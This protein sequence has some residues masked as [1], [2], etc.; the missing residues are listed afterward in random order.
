MMTYGWAILVVMAVGIV[1]WQTGVLNPSGATNG[2]RGFSQLD[3]LDWRM[4][5]SNGDWNLTLVVQNNAKTIVELGDT[6]D[7]AGA[8]AL[9]GGSGICGGIVEPSGPFPI[10]DFRPGQIMKIV[11]ELC[12]MDAELTYGDF[13]QMN[14]TIAY[15]NPA[16]GLPHLSNGVVWGPAG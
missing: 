11:F 13:Y 12:P 5:K 14:V 6:G 16:S 1:L 9:Q 4:A 7:G 8:I 10:T 3:I 15:V 2:K